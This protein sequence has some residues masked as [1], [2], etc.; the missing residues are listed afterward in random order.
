MLRKGRLDAAREVKG[1]AA[2]EATLTFI[3]DLSYSNLG[4]PCLDMFMD[5]AAALV[6]EPKEWALA[7]WKGWHG[8]EAA[9][10]Y[11]ELEAR[12]LLGTD[13][14]GNLQMHDV[15]RNVARSALLAGKYSEIG[16]RRWWSEAEDKLVPQLPQVRAC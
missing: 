6:G 15:I 11:A 3:L 9:L 7:V 16:L 10:A 13:E 14:R 2:S 4:S 5:V 1:T 8:D 12:C